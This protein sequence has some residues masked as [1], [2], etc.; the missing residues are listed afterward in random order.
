VRHADEAFD[1]FRLALAEP[2]LDPDAI[3]RVRGQM[4]AGLRHQQ[5]DPNAMAAKRF[6][7]E[8]FP[9]HPYGRP[10]QGTLEGVEAITRDDL[11]ASTARSSGG[12]ASS[13]RWSARSTPSA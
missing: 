7:R 9:G 10:T 1:L 6:F 8:A 11:L 12:A 2:R 5:N 13:S 3:E 4:I